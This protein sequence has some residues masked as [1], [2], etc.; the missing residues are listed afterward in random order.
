[1]LLKELSSLASPLN[2]QQTEQLKQAISEL[3]PQQLAWVSGYFWGISQHQPAGFTA[4]PQVSVASQPAPAGKL[5][6]IYASQT[7]NAKGVAEKLKQGAVARGIET[8]LYDASDYKGKNLAKESHVIIVASTNG[9]GEAPD[10]AIELHEFLQSK[11]APK[12]DKLQYGVIALGDSSY[13]FFCQTGK[14][15]DQYLSKLGAKSFLPRVDCDVDYETAAQEWSDSAL[16]IVEEALTSAPEAEVVQLPVA[17]SAQSQYSKSNPYSAT[18]LTNQKITGRDSGKDIR[19]I[20]IDLD[21]SGITYQPGDTLGVWYE[22]SPELADEI[23]NKTGLSGSEEIELDEQTITLRDALISKYEITS[24]NPQLVKKIAELSGSKKLL[25]LVDDNEKLR[26]Y[27]GKTQIADVL[28]EKKV[29]LSVAELTGLLRRL[30]PRLYSIAS[31]QAEVEDEVHLTVGLV[32]YQNGSSTR[33]GGAS[34]FLAQR[35]EEDQPVKVFVEHNNNFKLPE[36]DNTPVI[37]IGPG[38]G[39]APFRSFIQERENRDASGKSWLFFGDRTFTQDFLYQVEWQKYLKDGVLS[40]MDVAFSRDQKE[41][42]YVQDRLLENAAEVWQWIEQG[43]HIYVC[44]DAGHMAKDVNSALIEIAKTQGGLEAEQAESF[45]NGL[46][47]EKR[48][49][50]DVY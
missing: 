36:D 44:G 28:A 48:Y 10:N 26:A 33:L 17:N 27:A 45:I 3:S 50:R 13:E 8:E 24:A 49:Q 5:S 21:D 15:F 11:K 9:E 30:T 16:S 37:M 46:R 12:L 42:I 2:D 40:R 25:K 39:V 19:H 18:L 29:K 35:L 22:N 7:G 20:E 41:K 4:A 32:E 43:A 23:L 1:M 6:I 14:D 47:K 38:T 34:G 31:S